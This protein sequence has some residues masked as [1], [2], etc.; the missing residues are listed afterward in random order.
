MKQNLT[1]AIFRR[2]AKKEVN[3]LPGEEEDDQA[4]LD[5]K[6]EELFRIWSAPRVG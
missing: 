2:G 3:F 6:A 5:K 4:K 1:A